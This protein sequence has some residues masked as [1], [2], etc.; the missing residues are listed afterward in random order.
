MEAGFGIPESKKNDYLFSV[1][2]CNPM[3]LWQKNL[4][5]PNNFLNNS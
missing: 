1:A 2:F 4:D 5:D 3:T